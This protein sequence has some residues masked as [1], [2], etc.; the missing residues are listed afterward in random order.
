VQ[1]T[2]DYT[3]DYE[4]EATEGETSINQILTPRYFAGCE[5]IAALNVAGGT[6][7]V[8]G[9]EIVR[10][11]DLN[12]SGRSWVSGVNEDDVSDIAQD[13]ARHIVV[14]LRYWVTDVWW[15]SPNLKMKKAHMVSGTWV[16]E[17]ETETITTTTT[18]PE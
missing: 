10:W 17:E 9:E 11:E 16:I 8:V 7:V 18:C 6:G 3:S 13:I 2:Y 15:E 14:S 12:T 5:I 4:R 1:I